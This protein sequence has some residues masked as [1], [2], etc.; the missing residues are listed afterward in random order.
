MGDIEE[1]DPSKVLL[2]AAPTGYHPALRGCRAK[3]FL[4]HLLDEVAPVSVALRLPIAYRLGSTSCLLLKGM[5]TF[6]VG[7][8]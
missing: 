4:A 8:L 1:A 7:Y 5:V 2:F 6:S 3:V